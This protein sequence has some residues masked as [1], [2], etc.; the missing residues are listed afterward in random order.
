MAIRLYLM[1]ISGAGTK[2]DPRRPAY[3]DTILTPNAVPWSMMDYGYR[4]T[5]MVAADVTDTVNTLLIA[6]ADV[7]AFPAGFETSG[8]TVGSQSSS[9]TSTLEAFAIPAQW[10]QPSSTYLSVA[11]TVGGMFQFLQRMNGL[12][13]NVDPFAGA[14]L[15]TQI[16][17]LAQAT[18]DNITAAGLSFGW[19]LSGISSTTT[20]RNAIKY[21]AD[22]WGATPLMIGSF[23]F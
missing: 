5:C 19:N 12:M 8:A 20:L 11:H 6:N 22:Q 10:V 4:P 9:L 1:P 2:A 7:Y 18:Q 16:R 13:G 14:T 15:N 3:V 23:T 21:M 17:N